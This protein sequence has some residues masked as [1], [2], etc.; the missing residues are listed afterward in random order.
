M[1]K[2]LTVAAL[3]YLSLV[4]GLSMLVDRLIL[5]PSRE[6]VDAGDAIRRV[7]E[8]GEPGGPEVWVHRRKGKAGAVGRLYLL[9]FIGNASRA[10]WEAPIFLDLLAERYAEV[11]AWVLNYPGYGGSPGEAR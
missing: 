11:E 9:H 7:L 6:P 4:A 8:P 1:R 5:F 2:K 3:L 10:E